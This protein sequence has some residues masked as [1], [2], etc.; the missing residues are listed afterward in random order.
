MGTQASPDKARQKPYVAL[1]YFH[2]IGQQ[3]RYEEVSRLID[4]LNRYAP[5]T[6]D[7][8]DISLNQEHVLQF[9][10]TRPDLEES[11]GRPAVGYVPLLYKG[12]EYS[13]YEAYYA[14]LFAGG[15]RP[16]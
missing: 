5:E 13:M 4:G 8:N 10:P 14:Y 6:K 3:R 9:E 7:K 11:L 15:L 2:G 12:K 16:T 1:V